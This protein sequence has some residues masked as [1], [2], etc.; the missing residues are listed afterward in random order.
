M[1]KLTFFL[2]GTNSTGFEVDIIPRICAKPDVLYYT[3]KNMQAVNV[4]FA[5]NLDEEFS[6]AIAGYASYEK[7]LF[8]FTVSAISNLSG[9][10]AFIN[11][12]LLLIRTYR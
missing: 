12:Y 3:I 4:R 5:S 6:G 10:A 11:H 9:P 2:Q 7:G 1:I 8:F